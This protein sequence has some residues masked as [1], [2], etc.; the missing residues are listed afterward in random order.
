V[1][2]LVYGQ[3][4]EPYS[5]V[6]QLAKQLET[7]AA[8]DAVAAAIVYTLGPALK[9]PYVA[10]VL[11]ANDQRLAQFAQPARSNPPTRSEV[12]VFPLR[13][14]SELLGELQVMPST[15]ERLSRN[16]SLLLDNVARQ[17]SIAI[18]AARATADLQQSRERIVTAREEERRRLRRDLHDGLGPTLSSLYQ[19][20]DAASNLL[21]HDPATATRLLNDTK[22]QMKAVVAD[23]R[24][25][26]YS[27][28]PPVLDELGLLAAIREECDRLLAGRPTLALELTLP[29]ALP[30]LPAATEVAAYCIVIEAVTNVI[31]HAHASQCSIQVDLAPPRLGLSICDNGVGV[32]PDAR[33]G[34]GFQSMRERAAELGGW[35]TIT[36]QEPHGTLVQA[37]LPLHV[38]R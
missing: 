6:S 7:T 2:R 13:Y 29:P 35:V 8:P 34:V 16:H 5:V 12:V 10:I 28:R 31:K 24:R 9:L 23:I 36:P 4:D 11:T 30:P 32:P 3:R 33:S 26:V 19:R 37:Q 21:A 38:A 22:A 15:G 18:H 17:A 25:L 14:Q 1:N 20:I 27:L